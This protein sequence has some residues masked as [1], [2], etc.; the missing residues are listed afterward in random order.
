MQRKPYQ[1]HYLKYYLQIHCKMREMQ[2]SEHFGI[3]K[4]PILP[5]AEK[6]LFY[7][8]K[9]KKSV[10]NIFNLTLHFYSKKEREK[11]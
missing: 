10:K 7:Y 1:N 11:N 5:E 3:K 2:M 9:E 6:H 4:K 8:E